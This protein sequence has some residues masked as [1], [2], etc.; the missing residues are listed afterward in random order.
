MQKSLEKCQTVLDRLTDF[1]TNQ[2]LFAGKSNV[3]TTTSAP[4][5]FF[6]NKSKKVE[7]SKTKHP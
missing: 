5:I 1:E 6:L 3:W 2:T 7:K 4:D